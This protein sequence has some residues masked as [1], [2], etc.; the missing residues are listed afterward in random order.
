MA[1][2]RFAISAIKDPI[3][4]MF[5]GCATGTHFDGE[6]LLLHTVDEDGNMQTFRT[7]GEAIA[8]M[9]TLMFSLMELRFKPGKAITPKAMS[10]QM[11]LLRGELP[12]DLEGPLA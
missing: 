7:H 6:P 5:L 2:S 11:K 3:G 8:A 1:V 12:E 9:N 4:G 10:E